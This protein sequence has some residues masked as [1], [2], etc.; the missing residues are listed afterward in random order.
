M[1]HHSQHP[2]HEDAALHICVLNSLEP[3]RKDRANRHAAIFLLPRQKPAPQT[4]TVTK[5]K[6]DPMVLG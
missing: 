5:L 6:D 1:I 2:K 3:A 4:A